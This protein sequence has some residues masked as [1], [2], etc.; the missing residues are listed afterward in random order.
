MDVLLISKVIF[1][2]ALVI[3]LFAALRVGAYKSTAMGLLSSS[4]II[5]AF[6][7]ALL[8]VGDIYSITYTQ[9]IVLALIV[10]GFVGTIAYS[11][12]MG[13]DK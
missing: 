9:D 6:A 8:I 11:V 12:I 5:V 4:A 10:F 13:G 3:F 2:V 1:I 7:M